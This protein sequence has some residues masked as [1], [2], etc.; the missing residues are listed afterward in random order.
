MEA[1][2]P[3]APPPALHCR[4]F[5][6]VQMCRLSSMCF[7]VF[8]KVFSRLEEKKQLDLG[9]KKKSVNQEFFFFVFLKLKDEHRTDVTS[10]RCCCR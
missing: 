1:D 9:G 4:L 2:L 10:S 5:F 7:D 8:K 6:R 3:R